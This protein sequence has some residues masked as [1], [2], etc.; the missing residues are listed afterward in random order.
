VQP[1]LLPVAA[2]ADDQQR[3]AGALGLLVQR[4]RG[5][6]AA[7][8]AD[9]GLDPVG[10]ELR[11]DVLERVLRVVHQV[12][13]EAHADGIGLLRTGVDADDRSAGLDG[14][15]DERRAREARGREAEAH[16]AVVVQAR[17]EAREDRLAHGGGGGRPGR[18]AVKP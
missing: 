15:D 4:L 2:G 6:G 18:A 5:A 14:G 17:V 16:G 13:V 12:A 1:A 10:P 8:D 3:G 7:Q 9:L 11:L